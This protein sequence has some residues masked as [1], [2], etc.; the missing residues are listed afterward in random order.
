MGSHDCVIR[1]RAAGAQ[2]VAPHGCLHAGRATPPGTRGRSNRCGAAGY[3]PF[4]HGSRLA[5]VWWRH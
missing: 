5:F 1:A 3:T 2:A 4:G